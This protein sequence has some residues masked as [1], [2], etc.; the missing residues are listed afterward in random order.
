[1]VNDHWLA[2]QVYISGLRSERKSKVTVGSFTGTSYI[3]ISVGTSDVTISNLIFDLSG[4]IA[5]IDGTNGNGGF[6]QVNEYYC[7]HIYLD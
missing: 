2:R 7:V 4:A 5:N 6:L 3:D 1:L